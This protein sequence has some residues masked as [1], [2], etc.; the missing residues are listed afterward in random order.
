MVR[1]AEAHAE[2]DRRFH[3]LVTTRN[4]ADAIVHATRSSLKEMGEKLS[5]DERKAIERA[6]EGVEQAMKGD[7]KAAID[8]A[9]EQLSKAGQAIYQ[10]AAAETQT[11]QEAPGQSKPKDDDVV[12]AEFEEVDENKKAG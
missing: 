12:D 4:H 7:D 10:K 9:V 11:Q 8:N 5:E 2:E 6:I 1:D 3:E